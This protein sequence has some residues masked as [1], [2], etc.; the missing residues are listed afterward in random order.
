[1][2]YPSSKR[3]TTRGGSRQSSVWIAL[4]IVAAVAALGVVAFVLWQGGFDG[5]PFGISSRETGLVELWE[6]GDYPS[7]ISAAE[8]TLAENPV[9][10][11]ALVFGGFARYYSA[12]E[13]VDLSER[14]AQIGEAIAMLRKALVLPD[15]PL[16]PEIHY[17]LAKSYFER[18]RLYYDLTI[19]HMGRAI[20]L[21]YEGTDSLTYLGLAHEGLGDREASALAFEQAIEQSE[22]DLLRVKAAEQYAALGE[23]EIA[24]Q[25]LKEALALTEDSFV[26][27]EARKLLVETLIAAQQ[28]D[29]AEAM[30]L[31]QREQEPQS[32]DTL[33]YLGLVYERTDR[34]AEARSMWRQARDLDPNHT[35][36]LRRLAEME[37]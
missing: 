36:A 21:G 10:G 18:G 8:A 29:E 5:F 31:E 30:L 11:P 16:V 33:Y 14:G 7:V 24:E 26:E 9:H 19:H 13:Q 6:Q 25:H 34:I 12:I 37:E 3:S 28:F 27:S 23:V 1:M 35:D 4:A 17:V 20:E 15:P 32:A 2:L 22:T